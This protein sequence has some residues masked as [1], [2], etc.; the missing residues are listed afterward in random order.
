MR[1][2]GFEYMEGRFPDREKNLVSRKSHIIDP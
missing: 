1:C 2:I